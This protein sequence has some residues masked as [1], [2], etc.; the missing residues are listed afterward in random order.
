MIPPTK[1]L[2]VWW[3]LTP[4]STL[5]H[6]QE[7]IC[8]QTSMDSS[9]IKLKS[10]DLCNQIKK[11]NDKTKF[12]RIF[13]GTHELTPSLLFSLCLTI[14]CFLCSILWTIV[15]RFMFYIGHC[16]ALPSSS[17]CF[18]LHLGIFNLF[19]KDINFIFMNPYFLPKWLQRKWSKIIT[20]NNFIEN[21][22]MQSDHIPLKFRLNEKWGY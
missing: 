16:I 19:I 14:V 18:W 10:F 13:F 4:L 1:S 3:C 22:E 6:Q 12:R 17:Y 9:L 8:H 11:D 21:F 20:K 7:V 15:F 2:F 5:F